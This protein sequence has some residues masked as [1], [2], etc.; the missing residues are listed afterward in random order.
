MRLKARKVAVRKIVAFALGLSVCTNVIYGFRLGNTVVLIPYIIT[1]IGVVILVINRGGISQFIVAAK[2]MDNSL[3]IYSFI[4]VLSLMLVVIYFGINGTT[5]AISVKGL[6]LYFC[7]IA[8]YLLA[9]SLKNECHYIM[10]GLYWGIIINVIFCL[11]SFF[12]FNKGLY[13][14]LYELFP[15][16]AFAVNVKWGVTTGSLAK[17][18]V[19]YSYRAQGLF[20]EASHFSGF[21]I[22]L[23][24]PVIAYMK[25]SNLNTLIIV[26]VIYFELISGTPNFII[27]IVEAFVVIFFG[28]DK[29]QMRFGVVKK[30]TAYI[31]G[32]SI[33]AILFLIINADKLDLSAYFQAINTVLNSLDIA[34][35]GNTDRYRGMQV[36]FSFIKD[37]PLGIGYN[38]EPYL[39]N[40]SNAGASLHSSFS[41][42]LKLLVET[43]PLGF[44]SYIYVIFCF[45]R[46]GIKYRSNRLLFSLAIACLFCALMQFVNGIA[47]LPYM[48]LLFGL[49]EITSDFETTS[50]IKKGII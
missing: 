27:L 10:S 37:N 34:D 20:L 7:G 23:F 41:F 24:V 11:L 22:A 28:E 9:V 26:A 39:F 48:W 44:I 6:I 17:S 43:G 19:I 8:I 38:L 42:A 18:F 40:S 16:E 30:R 13:F 14:S 15:Q 12:A 25:K 32:V 47:I 35:V 5:I 29:K 1:L 45:C 46:K 36:G 2:K 21:L 4:N 50:R 3:K 49:T 33:I 31:M